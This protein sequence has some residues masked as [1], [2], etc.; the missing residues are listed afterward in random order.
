[1]AAGCVTEAFSTTCSVH[2]EDC[3]GWWVIQ[4]LQLSGSGS[5]LVAQ[6][7]ETQVQFMTT[8]YN[9]LKS[10]RWPYCGSISSDIV[11]IGLERFLWEKLTVGDFA[12]LG[13]LALPHCGDW[14]DCG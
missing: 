5:V 1:M 6:A 14:F 8:A 10:V 13:L 12:G 7:R 9:L 2:I 3:E 4:R 11:V